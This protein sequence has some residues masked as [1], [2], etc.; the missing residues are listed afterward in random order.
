MAEK[1]YSTDL[2]IS[3]IEIK[4]K[5]KGHAE[6][7]MNKFIDKIAVVMDDVIR[8]DESDWEIEENVLNEAT[9]EWI[10]Q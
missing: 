2:S 1:Y 7:L 4:A 5:N 8:W 3:I 10:K 9:G 6:R